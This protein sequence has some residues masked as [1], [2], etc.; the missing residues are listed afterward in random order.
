MPWASFG[1]LPERRKDGV[2]R[3][4]SRFSPKLRLRAADVMFLPKAAK[5]KQRDSVIGGRGQVRDVESV[6]DMA[7]IV[8]GAEGAAS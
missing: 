5:C 8:Q 4:G 3:E 2:A 6:T 7:E 1:G